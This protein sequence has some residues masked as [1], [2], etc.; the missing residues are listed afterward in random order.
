M[1]IGLQRHIVRFDQQLFQMRQL[2]GRTD[3]QQPRQGPHVQDA[4][5]IIETAAITRHARVSARNNLLLH[6]EPILLDV[7]CDQFTT[8]HHDVF[9]GDF[10]QIENAE[11][12]IPMPLRNH[13]ARFFHHGAQFFAIER[14]ELRA[15][16]ADTT[17][18]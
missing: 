13:R 7:D 8:R 5:D 12:H 11:Q 9:D 2:K 18:A 4:D 16:H 14:I 3:P 15:I 6:I 10:F 1:E 17:H